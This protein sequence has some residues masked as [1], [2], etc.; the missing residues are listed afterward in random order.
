MHAQCIG[1]LVWPLV[2]PPSPF[3]TFLLTYVGHFCFICPIM[4]LLYNICFWHFALGSKLVGQKKKNPKKK[5]G[6][7]PVQ[8][9]KS[10]VLL[11]PIKAL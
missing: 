11:V 3:S 7:Q 5:G 9:M 4:L 1:L 6:V 8:D 2:P 10:A